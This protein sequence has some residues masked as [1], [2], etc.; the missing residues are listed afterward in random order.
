MLLRFEKLGRLAS[1][2]VAFSLAAQGSGH[3]PHSG[4]KALDFLTCS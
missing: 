1:E 3:E 4:L 2:W